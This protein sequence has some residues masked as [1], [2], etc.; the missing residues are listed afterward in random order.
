MEPTQPQGIQIMSVQIF[1]V[2]Q[3]LK[4]ITLC[5]NGKSPVAEAK[6]RENILDFKNAV[7]LIKTCGDFWP[8]KI[9]LFEYIINAYM[10]SNDP[11]FMRKPTEEE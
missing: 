11:N 1:N 8:L 4:L 5:C 10:Y 9:A 2:I 3:L 7:R 6:C